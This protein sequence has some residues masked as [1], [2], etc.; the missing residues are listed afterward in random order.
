MR[1]SNR[2][3]S[4]ATPDNH[5]KPT[6][7]TNSI[8]WRQMR[9][10]HSLI[11]NPTTKRLR[12]EQQH[13]EITSSPTSRKQSSRTKLNGG[14]PIHGNSQKRARPS[15]RPSRENSQS[16]NQATKLDNPRSKKI[17]VRQLPKANTILSSTTSPRK[18]CRHAPHGAS[19]LVRNDDLGTVAFAKAQ[20]SK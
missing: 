2:F 13:D 6:G 20:A 3:K 15:T 8:C 17:P 1:Q 11:N 9:Q 10:R 12:W 19:D 7:N 14:N 5:H 18:T 4:I 16:R